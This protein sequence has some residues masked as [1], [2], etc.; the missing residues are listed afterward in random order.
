MSQKVSNPYIGPRPFLKKDKDWF[1]G[2]EQEAAALAAKV[3]SKR[4]VLFYAQSGAGKTSLINTSLIPALEAENFEVL[5]VGR[6]SGTAPPNVLA[7]N[8][9]VFN[10]LLNLNQAYGDPA[11]FADISLTQFLNYLARDD[12]ESGTC[13]YYYNESY[14]PTHDEILPRTLIIDQFEEL[15]TAYPELWRQREDFFCQLRQAMADDP[16][17]G[18]VLSIREDYV[19][20]LDPYAHLVPGKLRDRYYMQRMEKA[21]AK[22]AIMKPAQ[23]AGRPF[24]EE[25]AD[26]LVK[27]L[28]YIHVQSPEQKQENVEGQFIE[29]VQLQVVCQ[30]IWERLKNT[31]PKPIKI[32][33]VQ[34]LHEGRNL[35]SFID[36]SLSKFYERAIKRLL[37]KPEFDVTEM[38]LREW[39]SQQLI[40]EAQTR[41]TVHRGEE[42]TADLDTE[43]VDF[44]ASKLFLL[45][46]ETRAGSTWYELTHDRFIEPILKANRE[47]WLHQNP[48]YKAARE[49]EQAGRNQYHLY[50]GQQLEN[51]LATVNLETTEPI[52]RAFLRESKKA[53]QALEDQAKT[54]QHLRGYGILVMVLGAMA[55]YILPLLAC[56]SFAIWILLKESAP[57]IITSDFDQL[58][59][60]PGLW[61]VFLI[62]VLLVVIIVLAPGFLGA[63]AGHVVFRYFIQKIIATNNYLKIFREKLEWEQPSFDRKE[64][65]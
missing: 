60:H 61:I 41:G 16:Y 23:R 22:Q 39:F 18:V 15:F 62:A 31:P 32:K 27:N 48:V 9:Y 4:L 34:S 20:R 57:F 44:M 30:H 21:A 19:A 49:W 40:T 43:V 14:T 46:A 8:S 36:N 12:S 10:L 2:R 63:A 5:P 3:I 17:L 59:G 54:T 47:W 50:V 13:I 1:F 38:Q 51:A 11:R 53:N 37:R 28:S 33:D 29:P 45:R 65:E 56:L 64:T 6:V 35:E 7:K 26:R 58:L 42:Q 52:V 24:V 55:V 25:T